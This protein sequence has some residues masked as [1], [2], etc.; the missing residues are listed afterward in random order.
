MF[1]FMIN[2]V[3]WIIFYYGTAF[4][5]VCV[6]ELGHGIAG[7]ILGLNFRIEIGRGKKLFQITDHFIVLRE[8]IPGPMGYTHFYSENDGEKYARFSYKAKIF[9][10]SGGIQAQIIWMIVIVV[11]LYNEVGTDYLLLD[12]FYK[13]ML[14]SASII[15]IFCALI[16]DSKY[17]TDSYV[18]H[19]II[20]NE[21]ENRK[22]SNFP[23]KRA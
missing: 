1:Q 14:L 20:M 22:E 19:K 4:I 12:L 9:F 21:K 8:L 10:M 16:P 11:L 23:N 15:L 17:K 5:N 7:K 6:H 18:I 3:L 2:G 13:F